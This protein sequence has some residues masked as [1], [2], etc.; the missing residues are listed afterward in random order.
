MNRIDLYAGV[1]GCPLMCSDII[2]D[3]NSNIPRGF[4]TRAQVGDPIDL[5]VVGINPGQPMESEIGIYSGMSP[6]RK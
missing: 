5:M 6:G 4:Y 1:T 2:R 3:G